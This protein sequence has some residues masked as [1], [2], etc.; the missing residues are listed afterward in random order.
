MARKH[1][2]E[3]SSGVN[4][5]IESGNQIQ[6]IVFELRN[7]KKLLLEREEQLKD[8]ENKF[9]ASLNRLIM[10]E[11]HLKEENTKLKS[12]LQHELVSVVAH[13]F[14]MVI[15]VTKILTTYTYTYHETA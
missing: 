15:E 8:M 4:K 9:N 13:Y 3:A 12:E 7:S 1:D 11:M 6:N 14:L 2:P 10:S 5:V